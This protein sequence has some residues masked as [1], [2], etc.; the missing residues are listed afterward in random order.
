MIAYVVVGVL[1]VAM[2]TWLPLHR[3]YWSRWLDRQ[4][5]LD[6]VAA[7]KRRDWA[8]AKQVEGIVADAEA[9]YRKYS[10]VRLKA[11]L[12]DD[13]A[14]LLP[15]PQRPAPPAAAPGEPWQLARKNNTLGGLV[16]RADSD[17]NPGEPS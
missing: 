9:A 5:R 15:M 17:T 12:A 13:Y 6:A 4:A 10:D 1:V 14:S 8:L 7:E 11:A 3:R 2:L 16:E